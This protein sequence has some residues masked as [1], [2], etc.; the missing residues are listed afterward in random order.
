M[1]NEFYIETTSSSLMSAI[2]TSL[3]TR[4]TNKSMRDKFIRETLYK[5]KDES[6]SLIESTFID[7]NVDIES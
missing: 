3:R 7:E 4:N 6:E 1:M 5:L 2:P